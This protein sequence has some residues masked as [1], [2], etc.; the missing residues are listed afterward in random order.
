LKTERGFRNSIE[1]AVF[2]MH[3]PAGKAYDIAHL[4]VIVVSVIVTMLSS[5][6][7]VE[8]V[9]RSLLSTAEWVLT[10]L[11]T[12]DYILR[13]YSVNRRRSAYAFSFFGVVD[14]VSILPTYLSILVPGTRFLSTIRFLRILR[15]FRVFNLSIY[16]N[17]MLTL[18]RAIKMSRRRIAVFIFF[19]LVCVVVLGSLM[20]TIEGPENGFTSIPLSVYWAIVTLTTV[21]YGDVSPQTPLGQLLANVIMLLGYSIIVIP[22]GIVV[23]AR[24]EETA[25]RGRV[26][27]PE[28]GVS[29]HQKDAVHCRRCAAALKG[30]GN[31]NTQELR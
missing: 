5:V 1:S 12:V 16:Q 28:C 7:A 25:V 18:Y 26:S 6:T 3:T 22:T 8:R 11:L 15:V 27:C 23:T 14:L 29:D 20:Y 31:G 2:G 24:N 19:I 13:L 21:G 30:D 4:M 9:H 10:G 17:E